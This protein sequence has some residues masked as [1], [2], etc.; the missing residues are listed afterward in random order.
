MLS[1]SNMTGMSALFPRGELLRP[2]GLAAAR[3]DHLAVLIEEHVV[4]DDKQPLAL[5]ELV[6]RA[7]RERNG[8]A[9]A[10][11]NVVAP[12]LPGIDRAR[13]AHPVVGRRAGEHQ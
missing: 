3:A 2:D 13:A 9:G 4:V 1:V 7:R 5:D 12:G 6:E 8:V 11:G 10:G